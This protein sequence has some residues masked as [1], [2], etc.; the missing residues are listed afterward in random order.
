MA[1][2]TTLEQLAELV[3]YYI[4]MPGFAFDV[5]TIGSHPLDPRRN[6]VVW[7]SLATYGRS[8]TIPMG[9]PNGKLLRVVPGRTPGGKVSK[10]AKLAT[11][12]WGPAPAQ[13]ERHE[14]FT[15]LKPLLLS[16]SHFKVAH[17]TPFDVGSCEKY[18]PGRIPGPYVDTG[19]AAYLLNS[20]HRPVAG[21]AKPYALGSL[22]KR[23]LNWVY[24]K[25]IGK[26]IAAQSFADVA[27][28]SRLDSLVTWLLWTQRFAHRVHEVAKVW[29]LESQLIEVII[30]MEMEG[31]PVDVAALQPLHD[32]LEVELEELRGRCYKEAGKTFDLGSTQ[33]LATILFTERKLRPRKM[34]K[35]GKD[36]LNPKPS[37][38]AEALEPYR[39]RDK[40]VGAY[41]E[42]G[43]VHKLQSTYVTPYLQDHL[44]NGRIHAHFNA[45]GAETGRFSSSNP[46]LQNVP[47]PG[48]AKGKKIRGLFIAPEGY[49]LVVADYSQV[50]PRVY[51]GLSGDPAMMKAYLK[52]DGDFYTVIAE[53]FGLDRNV[54]KKM[55]LSVAYGIGPDKLAADAGISVTKAKKILDD[56]DVQFPV[57][58]E[59]KRKVIRDCRRRKPPHVLT[60]LGRRRYLPTIFAQDYG[61][62]MRAERQAFNTVIQG[63]AA[64]INKL[65]G[66][67]MHARLR[68]FDPRCRMLLTVHDEWVVMV[69]ERVAAEAAEVV[70]QAMEGIALLPVPLVADLKV[71]SRWADAK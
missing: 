56:F 46:N 43:D 60:L 44:V 52:D 34:T 70:R 42:H 39:T 40:L 11:K 31:A 23:E 8:D 13:L 24:D 1:V 27:L 19:V 47:R 63:G 26:D 59:F 28:Y 38:D 5:E 32:E 41:L 71:V 48:T 33:Q 49:Q 67:E 9:H 7:L 51:A 6:E 16:E 37:T 30:D 21:F 61:V 65:A 20:S 29:E 22:V 50:E 64:D 54:G 12:I 53:P 17:N 35:G 2:I 58:G 3:D 66:V 36:G 15:G 45:M 62:K 10:N 25:S 4:E 69:P 55:F 14:A 57:A 18:L 68:E